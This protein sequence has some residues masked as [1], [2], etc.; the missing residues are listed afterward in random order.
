[1]HENGL[2][3]KLTSFIR[4]SAMVKVITIGILI[5]LL[6][7]PTSMIQDLMRERLNRRDKAVTEISGKW[8]MSQTV[9]GPIVSVPYKKFFKDKDGK[10]SYNIQ[11]MHFLPKTLNISG[12]IDPKRK[13]RGIYEAVLYNTVLNVKG[14]FEF[15]D[16]H[17]M[18]ID[19]ENVI[20]KNTVLSIGITDMKGIMSNIGLKIKNDTIA[21]KPGIDSRDILTNGVSCKIN[22]NDSI[23]MLP[24][25]FDLNLNGS[26]QIKFVPIGEKTNIVLT[27]N[28]PSPSFN[29][30]FLPKN[31]VTS[32]GF[33]A[34]WNVLHLNRNYPQYWTGSKHY[35]H[36]S[37]FGVKLYIVADIYQQSMRTVKY[38]FM[39]I[40]FTFAAFFFSEIMV[41]KRVHPIQYLLVGF[42]ISIFYTLLIAI[43]EHFGFDQAYLISSIAIVVLIT[44]YSKAILH[45]TKFSV[46]VFSV[47]VL[48]YSYLYMVLQLEDYALLIGS[49]G[50][51]LVLSSIMFITRK[52]DWYSLKFDDKQ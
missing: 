18:N 37:A 15:P 35:I 38:A 36:N 46:A 25:E 43:S 7:I 24:F 30:S 17:D 52:I 28:W 51:F 44:A 22:F 26:Q 9:C 4:D 13:H 12:N 34:E 3:K 16:F 20:W 47:L 32:K 2:Q 11:Y 31:K 45:N 49:I 29:G 48:L 50:L 40:L 27:S 23:Q 5:L 42:A 19:L 14:S 33:D 1:M 39:F 8:G 41:R 6:M 21:M 10:S